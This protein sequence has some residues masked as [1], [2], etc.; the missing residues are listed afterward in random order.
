M[1]NWA[2]L[3]NVKIPTSD[4]SVFLADDDNGQAQS[5]EVA[6]SA[7]C[8]PVPWLLCFRGA[9]LH[10]VRVPLVNWR[11]DTPAGEVVMQLPFVTVEQAVRNLERSQA[12]FLQLAGD[13]ELGTQYWREACEGLVEMPWPYLA[14]DPVEVLLGG[15]EDFDASLRRCFD[16]DAPDVSTLCE[17]SGVVEG[18]APYPV[19]WIRRGRSDELT[20]EDKLSTSKGL[21]PSYLR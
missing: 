19:D 8:L 21:W 4:P 12:L 5:L 17:L 2:H 14:M 20:D 16:G 13:A 10:P 18:L 7:Y 1:A 9:E 6:D 11:D 15:W 3:F